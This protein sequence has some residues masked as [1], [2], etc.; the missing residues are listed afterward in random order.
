M[1]HFTVMVVCPEDTIEL[2]VHS[3]IKNALAPFCEHVADS[4]IY[5]V[6]RDVTEECRNQYEQGGSE[7]I[8]MPD[9]RLL[10]PWDDEFRKEGSFGFG[11]G[12]H[13]PPAE[14]AKRLIPYSQLYPTLETFITDWHGYRYC[15][16]KAAFGYFHNPNAKWDWW[17]LGG[18]WQGMLTAKADA[19]VEHLIYGEPGVFG[20]RG[21]EY[22]RPDGRLGCDGCR[23]SDLDFEWTREQMI[24]SVKERWDHMIAA[25]HQD[26]PGIRH[27]EYGFDPQS[28]FEEELKKA[29]T[30]HPFSTFAVLKA[31]K[32][33]EQ[34]EMGWFACVA[35]KKDHEQWTGELQQ[36]WD[37][38]PDDN[39]VVV[40]DCHI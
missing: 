26:N 10:L 23:K 28:L 38:I 2:N 33:Y 4:S 37:E 14:L 21:D 9:G 24:H 3:Y 30:G 20:A 6:F 15:E 35:N 12:T 13:E 32:W 27:F 31:S 34:G 22:T 17:A 39:I 29:E 18:R 11:S 7:R 36:I 5:A 25:G 1:S 19:A 40:V 8:I 16:E